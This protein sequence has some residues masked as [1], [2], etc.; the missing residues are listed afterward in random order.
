MISAAEFL[1]WCEVFHVRRGGGGGGDG[2][3]IGPTSAT[4][5]AIARF[6]GAS[7]KIIQNSA[8]TIDD[9]GN[10]T[11]P[12]A[13]SMN[14]LNVAGFAYLPPVNPKESYVAVAGDDTNGDGSIVNP[15]L[16]VEYADSVA[17]DTVNMLA[18]EFKEGAISAKLAAWLGEGANITQIDCGLLTLDD[19]LWQATSNPYK[20]IKDVAI[21]NGSGTGAVIELTL[22]APGSGYTSAP[23]IGFTGDGSGATA[24]AVLGFAVA[25]VAVT[26]PGSYASIPFISATTGVGATFVPRMTAQ[27]VVVVNGGTGYTVGA[28]IVVVGG[29]TVGSSSATLNID[30]VDG[31]GAITALSV[32]S[33]GVYTALPTNPITAGNNYTNCQV[34]TTFPLDAI[35]T[36]GPA[37]INPGVGAKLVNNGIIAP[38]FLDGTLVTTGQRVLVWTMTNNRFNGI[39]LVTYDGGAGGNWE[40]TRATDFDE[41]L[42]IT[43]YNRVQITAG[44][45]Y[46][47]QVFNVTTARPV[48]IGTGG[49]N[50]N[51]GPVYGGNAT[52]AISDWGLASVQVTAGGSG[53][54][55]GSSL[56]ISGAGGGAGTVTLAASGVVKRLVLT[57]PG[58]GYTSAPSVDF[59]GG[60]GTGAAATATVSPM[61][62]SMT[63]VPSVLKSGSALIFEGVRLPQNTALGNV[64]N[65][66]IDQDCAFFDLEITDVVDIYVGAGSG[67]L[68]INYNT[69]DV[70]T[71]AV[72]AIDGT[73]LTSID[74]EINTALASLTVQLTNNADLTN[75]FIN[76]NTFSVPITIKVDAVS[77]ASSFGVSADNPTYIGLTK[78]NGIST[79]DGF[80]NFLGQGLSNFYWNGNSG[81]DSISLFAGEDTHGVNTGSHNI[82]LGSFTATSKTGCFAWSD[83]TATEMANH[84]PAA[85]NQFAV[86]PTAGFGICNDNGAGPL[87]GFH[88]GHNYGNDG[89][90]I[91]SAQA[92]VA[93]ASLALGEVNTY[94]GNGAFTF[95]VRQPN[96]TVVVYNI[97]A[98][99]LDSN[100]VHKTGNET[101]AGT[102]TFTDPVLLHE[103]Q[104]PFPYNLTPESLTAAS[105][106]IAANQLVEGCVVYQGSADGAWTL[107]LGSDI[108]SILGAPSINR[109]MKVRLEN[110]TDFVFSVAANT[111]T[112]LTGMSS[113][114]TIVIPSRG[115][116]ICDLIRLGT[117][118]YSL[119]GGP[120]S[121][122][123]VIA[124]SGTTKTFALTDQFSYQ[125]CSNG[126]TQTLTIP[127]NSVIPFPIGTTIEIGQQGAGQVVMAATGGVTLNSVVGSAPKSFAQYVPF[128]IKKV[129]V[130][131]WI[132][133]GALTS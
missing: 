25:S 22:T 94:V 104:N 19:T 83:H 99:A 76:D 21:F 114:I 81:S 102:K 110:Q 54:E 79:D 122:Y 118:S 72:I 27:S 75:V 30:A 13:M 56:V 90:I 3:V 37:P 68:V 26:L 74:V 14:I 119:F 95:K 123:S 67:D 92:A 117:N 97:A 64:S 35:Y 124:V 121:G 38:L 100:V 63:F 112:T 50:I 126:S 113:P 20:L 9:S 98:L 73:Y 29:T 11:T 4:P 57:A 111:G 59:S 106:T 61:S 39:Y 42:E 128:S 85:D 32:D 127:L 53:Y 82:I 84:F 65:V 91:F 115:S 96:N 120:A 69:I 41:P 87:A 44:A 33:G 78:G 36:D 70:L 58:S 46:A 45:T 60:G 109:G 23:A 6:N 71:D 88:Y 55:T 130:D 89:N 86:W 108:D 10:V 116:V 28:K 77:A 80:G 17:V 49:S 24:T 12:A 16:T 31:V 101:I 48:Q 132:A 2:D 7:G 1:K 52:F 18:G 43:R 40:M 51:F 5:N 129:S 66:S 34:A 62:G 103:V 131:T 93:D 107:P 15:Y 125:A 47:G 133:Y 8:V 105:G